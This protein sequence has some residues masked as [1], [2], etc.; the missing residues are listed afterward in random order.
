MANGLLGYQQQSQLAQAIQAQNQRGEQEFM[1][2]MLRDQIEGAG[3]VYMADGKPVYEPGLMDFTNKDAAL[4]AFIQ[5]RKGRVSDAEILA[6]NEQFK[7]MKGMRESKE[8]DNLNRLSAMGL[9][10]TKLRK[11]VSN[12]P[13]LYGSVVDRIL[14][15]EGMGDEGMASAALLRSK[16]LPQKTFGE[17]M[18]ESF[19]DSPLT[20]TAYTAV[21]L[22]ALSQGYQR[23]AKPWLLEKYGVSKETLQQMGDFTKGHY[24]KVG[25]NWVNTQKLT[26]AGEPKKIGA[27]TRLGRKLSDFDKGIKPQGKNILGNIARNAK[28]SPAMGGI[29]AMLA[30]TIGRGIAGEEGE[31]IGRLGG[32][33]YFAREGGKGLMAALKRAGTKAVAT[34]AAATGTGIGNLPQV[35]GLLAL[36][37]LGYGG[38]EVYK[39]LTGE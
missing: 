39:A 36:A 27:N 33:A 4:N 30:P 32:G 35:R 28:V 8:M 17:K 22:G 38:S 7:Q 34:Q 2:N 25:D 12:N 5:Y 16:F 24:K 6:F 3:D 20:T 31:R 21:G 23:W 29:G 9:S 19:E 1:G 18:A 14:A 13:A 26:Q 37:S 11:F 10:D 15:L